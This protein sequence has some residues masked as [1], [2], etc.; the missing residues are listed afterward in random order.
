[1]EGEERRTFLAEGGAEVKALA[2]TLEAKRGA[3]P[4]PRAYP[5]LLGS[6]CCAAAVGA[7]ESLVVLT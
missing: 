7:D 3:P 1:M 5:V 6:P 2:H 4:R